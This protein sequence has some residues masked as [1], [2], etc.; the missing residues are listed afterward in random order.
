MARGLQQ[1]ERPSGVDAEIGVRIARGPVVGWLGGG[2]NDQ[3][4]V[5]AELVEQV[6]HRRTVADVEVVMLVIRDGLDEFLAVGQRGRAVAKK[7]LAQVIVDARHPEAFAANR[8]TLSEPI[9]PAAP[10]TITVLI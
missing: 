1:I 7:P 10:V 8:L 5:L 2:V 9:N 6:F 4:D 3:G